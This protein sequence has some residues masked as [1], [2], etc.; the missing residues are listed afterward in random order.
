[1]QSA[2]IG[3][4]DRDLASC[5]KRTGGSVACSIL[6]RLHTH[7]PSANGGGAQSDPPDKSETDDSENT[8]GNENEAP[9]PLLHAQLLP[10]RSSDMTRTQTSPG[11]HETMIGKAVRET[12]SAPFPVMI[13]SPSSPCSTAGNSTGVRSLTFPLDG[14]LLRRSRQ[15]VWEEF[16]NFVYLF[17]ALDNNTQ[18]S[19]CVTELFMV[20]HGK[21]KVKLS[22]KPRLRSANRSP[23][24]QAALFN[25]SP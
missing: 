4:A 18:K 1:M 25:I 6:A 14:V 10:P 5:Q 12:A 13:P 20:R 22:T 15:L 23:H 17:E 8:T 16:Y 7:D 9:F 24:S 21:Y 19:S 3:T 11:Q 2:I